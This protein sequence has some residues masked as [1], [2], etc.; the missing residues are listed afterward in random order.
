MEVILDRRAQ[1]YVEAGGGDLYLWASSSRCCHGGLAMLRTALERPEAL[2]GFSR[3]PHPMVGVWFRGHR[4]LTD[5]EQ[6]VVELHGK[7]GPRL[8]AFW[9]G[10]VYAL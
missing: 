10:C 5:P 2:E 4:A 9:N 3:V 6:V 1:A 7:R 8:K